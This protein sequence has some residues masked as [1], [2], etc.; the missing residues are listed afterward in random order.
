MRS[1]QDPRSRRCTWEGQ[2]Y[3]ALEHI[4]FSQQSAQPAGELRVLHTQH[5]RLFI[6]ISGG[7]EKGDL[8]VVLLGFGSAPVRI[9]VQSQAHLAC[10]PWWSLGSAPDLCLPQGAL[11]LLTLGSPGNPVRELCMASAGQAFS[12]CLPPRLHSEVV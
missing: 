2:V 6:P 11:A 10:R 4:L 12:H 1:K 7:H 3:S 8:I 5:K 9:A